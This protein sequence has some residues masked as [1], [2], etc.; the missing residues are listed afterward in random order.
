MKK[1]LRTRNEVFAL[2]ASL[3]VLFVLLGM[4]SWGLNQKVD[5]L[6][7]D[8]TRLKAEKAKYDAIIREMKRLEADKNKLTAKI[9]VIKKLKSKSQIT[10][11]LL[12]EVSTATPPDSIWLKSFKQSGTR[13][14]LTGIALD[15]TRIA[16]YM[17]SLTASSYFS[18][19]RLG[20]SSLV[21]VA[22]QKLKKFSLNLQVQIPERSISDSNQGTSK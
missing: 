12:D 21:T 20:N 4:T 18:G 15:N 17:D 2:I 16:D 9:D 19:A 6:K 22:G 11:H 8:V 3:V 7:Q 13:V 1:R 14:S 5:S 10:V